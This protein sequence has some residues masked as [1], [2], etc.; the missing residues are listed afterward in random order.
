MAKHEWVIISSG[1]INDGDTDVQTA[2]MEVPGGVMFRYRMYYYY[3]GRSSVALQFIPGAK[4]S[5][6]TPEKE[7]EVE[8]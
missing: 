2:V 8:E 4:I 1:E 5:D 7:E 3:A 6:F